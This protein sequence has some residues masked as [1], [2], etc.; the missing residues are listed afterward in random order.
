M[1]SPW[2]SRA[3][4]SFGASRAGAA[5]ARPSAQIA[6]PPEV[7]DLAAGDDHPRVPGPDAEAG[8]PGEPLL[9]APGGGPPALAVSVLAAVAGVV[10]GMDVGIEEDHA[11]G[12]LVVAAPDPELTAGG[13]DGDRDAVEQ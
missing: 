11:L 3:T 13:V 6:D 5:K 1:N 2:A 7:G 4:P 10:R 12:V 8:G 9:P